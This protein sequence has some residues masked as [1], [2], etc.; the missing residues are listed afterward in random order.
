MTSPIITLLTDFGT[1]DAYAGIMKG[2]ILGICPAARIVDLSHE[3]PPQD[4]TAGALLLRSAYRYF[5]QG[6]IHVA[7]VDPGVGGARAAVL[8]RT[9]AATFIG[10]DNGLL[11][12]AA[13][14]AGIEAVFA[15]T[16]AEF[17]LPEVSR[18][19]H[20]RDLFAPVAAH[21]A[22]GTPPDAFG[23]TLGTLQS[24]PLAPPR[25]SPAGCIGEVIHVDRFGN[26]I[27]NIREE[28]LAAFPAS[29]L[30]VSIDGCAPIPIAATYADG[31][32]RGLLAL[33]GSWG[34]LEVA[35]RDGSAATRL[36]AAVGAVVDVRSV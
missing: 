13:D 33:I 27:T 35:V 5:P 36:G 7:V 34:H 15:L 3:V 17:H 28:D 16:R 20:G 2:V 8:V 19:F 14:E 22:G 1:A 23:P 25:R 30:S 32:A 31:E 26:L 12:P 6:T 11:Q 21:L 4:I 10:P 9:A 29:T 18:T 24:L